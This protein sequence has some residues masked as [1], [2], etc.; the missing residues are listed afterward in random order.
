MISLMSVLDNLVTVGVW[1]VVGL[2]GIYLVPLLGLVLFMLFLQALH[3]LVN[4]SFCTP[5]ELAEYRKN[6]AELMRTKGWGKP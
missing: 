2:V 6:A 1:S 4:F 3:W 5:E